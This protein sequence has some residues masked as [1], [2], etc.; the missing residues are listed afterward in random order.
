MHIVLLITSITCF[1][2]GG[3]YLWSAAKEWPIKS[4]YQG[5]PDG[6]YKTFTDFEQDKIFVKDVYGNIKITYI[7]EA[8]KD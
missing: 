1:I 5:L 4:S 2:C 6:K 7:R 3:G 8:K